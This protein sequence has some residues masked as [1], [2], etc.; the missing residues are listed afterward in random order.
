[1]YLDLNKLPFNITHRHLDSDESPG[2]CESTERCYA[3]ILATHSNSGVDEFQGS[4]V[5][6]MQVQA[7]LPEKGTCP[8]LGHGPKER[9]LLAPKQR[10]LCF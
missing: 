5:G 7:C 3:E 6:E 4:A 1:M 2:L 9:F 8:E 10:F